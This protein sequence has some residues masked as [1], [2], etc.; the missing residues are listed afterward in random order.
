MGFMRG[1]KGEKE[2]SVKTLRRAQKSSPSTATDPSYGKK[3]G[4]A[5]GGTE[6]GNARV[7]QSLGGSTHLDKA[8][9]GLQTKKP[10][11]ILKKKPAETKTTCPKRRGGVALRRVRHDLKGHS[12]RRK[13]VRQEKKPQRAGKKRGRHVRPVIA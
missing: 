1:E 5:K 2:V 10:K 6:K 13:E 3:P 7:L 4:E 12:G 8:K 11:K 9:G